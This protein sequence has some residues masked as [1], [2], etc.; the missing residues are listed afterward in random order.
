MIE[1][2]RFSR[3]FSFV[4]LVFENERHREP[5]NSRFSKPLLKID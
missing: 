1:V 4:S 3:G 5:M 2:I